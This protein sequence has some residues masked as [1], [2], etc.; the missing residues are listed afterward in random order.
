MADDLD[1][2]TPAGPPKPA[3]P[4]PAAAP[5]AQPPLYIPAVARAF[6][7]SAGKEESVDTGTVFFAEN[8]K[9][10]RLLLKR[11]KMYYLLEGQVALV[12][13]GQQIGAPKVGEIFG[14]MAAI[15]D[16][17]RSATAVAKSPCRVLSLDDKGFAAALQKKPEFALMMLGT[18]IMRLRGMIAKLS[19]IP[20]TA[21][22]KESR[23]FDKSLL[24]QMIQGLGE[25]SV[26]RYDKGKIIMVAGQAGA[27]MYV[28]TEGRVAISIRG[29]IVERIGPGGIFGEMA[30]V[31]QS[32]RAANAV[33]ETE[34][35]L[36]GINRNVFLNLVKSTPTFGIALLS[37]TAERLR[38]TAA[39][40]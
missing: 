24:G 16:S 9:A 23:V 37:A 6:F 2:S 1:F 5:S 32:P 34:V 17:P 35:S 20:S 7:E 40:L 18:M 25:Q 21:D 39:A 29:A 11:D 10:S 12:A 19:G 31:D 36:L 30:L 13:K 4:K 33:A 28:V 14:E 15:S 27:L 26:V 38:N 3:A 8:E 22:V